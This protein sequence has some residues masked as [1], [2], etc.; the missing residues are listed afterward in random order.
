MCTKSYICLIR[1]FSQDNVEAPK[2][3]PIPTA[4]PITSMVKSE[5]E[6]KLEKEKPY[7]NHEHNSFLSENDIFNTKVEGTSSVLEL[8]DDA[9][10]ASKLSNVADQKD[11]LLFVDVNNESVEVA[12]VSTKS[13]DIGY[14]ITQLVSVSKYLKKQRMMLMIQ[15]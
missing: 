1:V 3:Y 9:L 10:L 12:G 13:K 6:E 2:K 11:S 4:E 8:R 14:Q 5:P 15:I 7:Q